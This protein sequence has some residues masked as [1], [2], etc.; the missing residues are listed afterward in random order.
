M[1]SLD[2]GSGVGYGRDRDL[3]ISA[4]PSADER[5]SFE[6][7][8]YLVVESILDA[9]HVARLRD[10]LQ[11][12]IARRRELERRGTPHFARPGEDH[13]GST[14]IFYLLADDPLFLELADYPPVMPYIRALLNGFRNLRPGVPMLE[15]KIGYFL[16]D[17]TQPDQGNLMLVPGSHKTD[18][19]PTAEALSGF[20]SF[21]GA[22]QVCCPEGSCVIFHNALSHTR[23]P[24][25][26]ADGRCIMLYYAYEHPWMIGSPNT[27]PIRARSTPDCP[28][29]AASCSTTSCSDPDTMT[30]EVVL[31][32]ERVVAAL[33]PS[34]CG[35]G[36]ACW[37]PLTAVP[38]PASPGSR[39][40]CRTP[41]AG[42][43][44]PRW[45]ISTTSS[46]AKVSAA[47]GWHG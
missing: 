34:G 41:W 11:R 14:R 17:M 45:C 2:S 12:A 6:T 33:S 9:E 26:R 7:D 19:E 18:V 46:A 30:S 28:A 40:G 15:L 4:V 16:S 32:P 36:V 29:P 13:A 10:A 24:A 23:G 20:D 44:S 43:S 1:P 21:P 39:A 47:A 8:G 35:R 3:G 22:T 31:A 27:P 37:W 25:T 38:A 5:Y 42:T